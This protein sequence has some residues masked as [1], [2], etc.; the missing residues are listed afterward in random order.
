[1]FYDTAL[2]A[3]RPFCILQSSVFSLQLASECERT[4]FST[5]MRS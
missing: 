1:M 5:Q 3:I 4:I 2:C